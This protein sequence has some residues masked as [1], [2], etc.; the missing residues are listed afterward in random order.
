MGNLCSF[1]DEHGT[2]GQYKYLHLKEDQ[3]NL[4]EKMVEV[5]EP[6]QI[7]TTALCETQ[8]VPCLLIY[9]VVSGLLKTNF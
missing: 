9:P 1:Y 8:I 3:W 4:M 2:Q 6:L 7:A 5:L